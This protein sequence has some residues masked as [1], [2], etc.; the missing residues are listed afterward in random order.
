MTTN[1]LKHIKRVLI[2]KFWVAH[3][4]FKAGLYYQ[5][6]VHDLSKFSP[7]E[8]LESMKYYREGISPIKVAREDKGYSE[9]ILH[10]VGHNRHH[11]DYWIDHREDGR[12]VPVPIPLQ[13][14]GE[15][16]CDWLAAARTY[17]GYSD[18]IYTKEKA[19]WDSHRKTIPMNENSRMILDIWFARLEMIDIVY[20]RR[21]T[22]RDT[23][24][25]IKYD[26]R[27]CLGSK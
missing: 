15:M 10:H 5:G 18:D 1:A 21:Y 6:L 27:S 22:E 25:S 12:V 4:C 17:Q 20:D 8:M 11:S 9:A 19:W 3:Y 7:T 26:I 23:W 24:R 16:L 14:L 2:H 13:Y